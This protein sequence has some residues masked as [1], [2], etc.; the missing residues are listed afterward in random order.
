MEIYFRGN[1]II[2]APINK[3]GQGMKGDYKKLLLSTG[4]P[5][6][7]IFTGLIWKFV[8]NEDLPNEIKVLILLGVA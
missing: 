1:K 8:D 5:Y 4:E 7:Y 3:W 6:W 2:E